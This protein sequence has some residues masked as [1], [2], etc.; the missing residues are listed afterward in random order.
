MSFFSRKKDV[1]HYRLIVNLEPH[2]VG[3]GLTKAHSSKIE[4]IDRQYISYS[5]KPSL[6]HVQAKVK[7]LAKHMLHTKVIP[8]I[9]NGKI[10]SGLCIH[11]STWSIAEAHTLDMHFPKP[12]KVTERLVAEK[13]QHHRTHSSEQ[14]GLRNLELVYHHVQ[15]I[16]LNGYNAPKPFG[17]TASHISCD[18]IEGFIDTSMKKVSEEIILTYTNTLTHVPEGF[19]IMNAAQ[20]VLPQHKDVLIVHGDKETTEI[21]LGEGDHM[22]RAASSPIGIHHII[23]SLAASVHGDDKVAFSHLHMAAKGSRILGRKEYV[24]LERAVGEWRTAFLKTAHA[25]CGE[26]LPESIA[27]YAALQDMPIAEF[28]LKDEKI[29]VWSGK[30]HEITNL[31]GKKSFQH[32]LMIAAGALYVVE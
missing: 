18:L 27:F 28:L 7:A 22:R 4:Y 9:G 25:L 23:R 19:I 16:R 17:N 8:F 24:A 29:A 3:I 12:V 5:G 6:H 10:S 26:N 15:N 21:M 11:S 20:H 31:F 32:D 14:A 13:I 2:S 30:K 1:A